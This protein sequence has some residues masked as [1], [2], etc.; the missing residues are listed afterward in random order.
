MP[1]FIYCGYIHTTLSSLEVHM[2]APS[3]LRPWMQCVLCSVPPLSI[4]FLCLL[5]KHDGLFPETPL[6]AVADITGLYSTDARGSMKVYNVTNF[7]IILCIMLCFN[8]QI[9]SKKS[10]AFDAK[11]NDVECNILLVLLGLG[12]VGR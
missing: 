4:V 2:Y 12:C 1:F 7:F 8:S 3:F 11:E 9:F 6:R 5:M 10:C